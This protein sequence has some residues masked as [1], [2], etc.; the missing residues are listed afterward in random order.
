MKRWYALQ[1]L[2]DLPDGGEKIDYPAGEIVSVTTDVS[3]RD[4][5]GWMQAGLRVIDL[6]MHPD[7]GPDFRSK[8]INPDTQMLED[9]PPPPLTA[10]QELLAKPTWTPQDIEA[11]IREILQRIAG[12]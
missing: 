12:S 10:A 7:N 1:A 5:N 6:G 8:R 4:A 2:R 9:V 3:H 11:A